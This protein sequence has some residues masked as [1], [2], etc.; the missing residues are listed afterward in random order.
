MRMCL[1]HVIYGFTVM[2]Y[3]PRQRSAES[4]AAK[5]CP[6]P[7]TAGGSTG[8][9]GRALGARLFYFVPTSLSIPAASATAETAGSRERA[10]A[11]VHRE[12]STQLDSARAVVRI[13][14]KDFDQRSREPGV[15]SDPAT[16]GRAW[17]SRDPSRPALFSGNIDFDRL[18]PDKLAQAYHLLVPDRRRAVAG[19]TAESLHAHPEIHHEPARGDLGSSVFRSPERGP[20]DCEPDG[21]SDRIPQRTAILCRRNG[22]FK[23][24]ATAARI[25]P[26]LVWKLCATWRRKAKSGRRWC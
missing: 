14:Q 5:S 11:G 15:I 3:G 17:L 22:S 19:A 25:W 6:R 10:Q 20:H 16:R 18:W 8:C 12:A 13:C 1:T 2:T 23:M 4:R 24:K 9:G 21:G 26:D 7:T